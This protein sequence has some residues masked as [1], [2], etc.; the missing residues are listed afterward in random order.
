MPHCFIPVAIGELFDKYSIL[1]IKRERI[2]NTEKK[3]AVQLEIDHL[4]P[5]VNQ[6][7]LDY[8]IQKQLKQIN[9]D[10]WDIEEKIR[11]KES[12]LEF[13]QQFIDLARRVYKTNDERCRIKNKI[14]AL[15][16][17]DIKEMKSYV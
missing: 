5:F 7:V 2:A 8:S 11:E 6:Y 3:H 9:E 16:H 14:N 15:L 17:S 1:L 12:A 13:D 4:T 10:L